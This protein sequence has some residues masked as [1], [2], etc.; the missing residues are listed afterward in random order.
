LLLIEWVDFFRHNTP[1]VRRGFGLNI[2][3]SCS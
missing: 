2:G 1:L 3:G